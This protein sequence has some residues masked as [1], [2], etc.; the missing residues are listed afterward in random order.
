MK[1][2]VYISYSQKLDKFYV[3]ITNDLKRRLS[4][5]NSGQGVFTNQGRPWILLWTT[6]KPSSEE[7]ELLEQKLKN[8]SRDRKIKFM[9][10]YNEGVENNY[11][12]Q[13][14]ST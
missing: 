11:I 13:Q 7:A 2:Y 10:K 9:L 1:F 8:L 6:I 4:Q 12:L 5:H 3:G 14:L